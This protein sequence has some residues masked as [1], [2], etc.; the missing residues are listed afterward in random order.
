MFGNSEQ[1]GEA[2]NVS[3]TLPAGAKFRTAAPVNLRGVPLGNPLPVRDGKLALTLRPYAP[4]SF[5]LE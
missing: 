4:A 1:T 3:V 5:V 2:G